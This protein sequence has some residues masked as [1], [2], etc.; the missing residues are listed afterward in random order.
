MMK[1]RRL[2]LNI[3]PTTACDTGCL[4]CID[5]SCLDNPSY[6]TPEMATELINQAKKEDIEISVL[7]SG[8]GEP[9]MNAQLAE[10]ATIFHQYDKFNS[11]HLITSG[12][13][14]DEVLRKD[15]FKKLL[16]LDSEEKRVYV[17]QSFS[18]YQKSFPDRLTNMTRLMID[19]KKATSL[20][21]RACISCE[22]SL[23]TLDL[24]EL[25]L[26][27]L[28]QELDRDFYALPIGYLSKDRVNFN[29]SQNEI[30]TSDFSFYIYS[31]MLTISVLYVMK[32]KNS[33]GGIVVTV[34]PFPFVRKGRAEKTQ[35]TSFSEVSCVPMMELGD[36]SLL[37]APDGSVYADCGCYPDTLMQLGKIGK[38][39]LA[40]IIN[41]RDKFSAKI[42]QRFL[43]DKRMCRWGTDEVCKLCKQI[44][45]ED[46]LIS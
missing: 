22:N 28:A 19:S 12:F 14:E 27:N 32:N 35:E 43:A 39:S 44:V 7:F 18:L 15:I 34:Y 45:A 17:Y 26:R 40:D 46:G 36:S 33:K 21:V 8:G 38:N 4:H 37:I 24:A 13:L 30:L 2:E 29:F 42:T 9:L 1:K 5:N 31:K 6:F 23:E 16:N 11:L 25:T 20:C 41:R 10:I 3:Y